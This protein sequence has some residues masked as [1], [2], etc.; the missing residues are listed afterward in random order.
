MIR[1]KNTF[2]WK[3][4]FRKPYNFTIS[5]FF[6]N[7]PKYEE[8]SLTFIKNFK[9]RVFLIISNFLSSRDFSPFS[10]KFEN[11]WFG[12]QLFYCIYNS[13]IN[14][15]QIFFQMLKLI[16]GDASGFI[17]ND[18]WNGEKRTG[19]KH[20]P[21]HF[22]FHTKAFKKG[23]KRF[24][25]SILYTLLAYQFCKTSPSLISDYRSFLAVSTI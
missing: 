4:W 13:V 3:Y 21:R 1:T 10:N 2:L 11:Y 23:K 20:R 6:F 7:K 16:R 14:R 25:L 24:F 22:T 9:R 18:T 17:I 8:N 12:K 5:F 19:F 15:V